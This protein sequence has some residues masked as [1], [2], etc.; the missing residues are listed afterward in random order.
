MAAN[1]EMTVGNPYMALLFLVILLIIFLHF[2]FLFHSK[3]RALIFG[4]FSAMKRVTSGKRVISK[5]FTPLFFIVVAMSL[6]ILSLMDLSLW[7]LSDISN[8]DYYILLDSGAS[9]NARDLF[10]DRHTVAKEISKDIVSN[11]EGAELGFISFGGEIIKSSPLTRDKSALFTL[12][13]ETEISNTGTDIGLAI[14]SAIEGL[15]ISNKT[16]IIIL[17]SDG[18]DTVGIPLSSALKKAVEEHVKIFTVGV[19]TTAGG[20]FLSVPKAKGLISK[21]NSDELMLLSNRTASK[22]INVDDENRVS[23]IVEIVKGD[24]KKGFKEVKLSS[25]F[26]TAAFVIIFFNWLLSNTRFRVFP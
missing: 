26:V 2:I 19:G 25:I 22:Y 24:S 23:N 15:K 17:L 1:F 8:S 5:N 4:N 11:I 6:M 16:K 10:P 20:S 12:I 3:R 14:V 9:M 21:L 7:T 18:H 13:D